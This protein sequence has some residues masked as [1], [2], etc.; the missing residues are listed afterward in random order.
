MDGIII[1]KCSSAQVHIMDDQRALGNS[2]ILK[3]TPRL[4][5]AMHAISYKLS[6]IPLFSFISNKDM[7][8]FL[9]FHF[10]L[11]EIIQRCSH[12]SHI[13]ALP[14]VFTQFTF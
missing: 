13:N 14:R 7:A 12:L 10:Y 3:N 4:H 5:N 8:H 2:N 11:N 1:K 9:V 6:G